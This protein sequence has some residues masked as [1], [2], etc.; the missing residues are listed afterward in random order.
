M[1]QEQ[2]AGQV[3]MVVLVVD[4]LGWRRAEV[5]DPAEREIRKTLFG[6]VS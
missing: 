1:L 5:G 6:R 3:V 2:G 4:D